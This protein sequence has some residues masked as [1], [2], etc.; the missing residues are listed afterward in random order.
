MAQTSKKTTVVS[1]A[2][3]T[4][5]LFAVLGTG[6]ADARSI[7][8]PFLSSG[9]AVHQVP[10]F[11]AKGVGNGYS[12]NIS[13]KGGYLSTDSSKIALTPWSYV[14]ANWAS[15]TVNIIFLANVT[16]NDFYIAFLYLT[17]S[18]SQIV[19]RIF[20]YQGG[21]YNTIVVEGTQ[22]ISN[23]LVDTNPVIIPTPHFDVKSQAPNSFTV[24]GREI[25]VDG[26]Y[27]TVFNSSI[28]LKLA[29][30]RTQV[31]DGP[32][33][34][35]EL[36][37]L[38]SD[39][40]GNYYFAIL[41]MQNSDGYHTI[42]EHQLRLNDFR[43]PG[44][45]TFDAQWVNGHFQSS[46]QIRLPTSGSIVKVDGFPFQANN[47]GVLSVGVPGNWATVEVPNETSPANGMRMR[48]SSWDNYGT[49]NP[50]N[51]SVNS[52]TQ[53]VA[54]YRVEY[55]LTIESK[56]SAAKGAGWYSAGTNATF[57]VSRILSSENGTRQVF[58]GFNGDYNS[59]SSTGYIVM[60]SA[61][62]VSTSWKTQYDVRLQLSGVPTNSTVAVN[63]N[64]KLQAVNGSKTAELWADNN[65]QLDV[66][67]PTTQIQA[68]SV[69]YNFKELQVDGQLSTSIVKVTKPITITIVFSDQQ[70][71]P[72]SINVEVTP[73]SA[74][75]GDPVIISGALSV[76]DKS[77][78]VH[79]SFSTDRENW[80]P[81]ANVS[82][83]QGGLFSY[84]WT[85]NAPGSY[86]V[87]AY[88][89][90]DT[91]HVSSSDMVP[92]KVQT[93]VPANLGGSGNLP[94]L[95]QEFSNVAN[96]WP[97]TSLPIALA[98]SFLTLGVVLATLL[99]S[100]GAPVVGYFIG[101]LL[102]GFVFVFPISAIILAYR[103]AKNRRPPSVVWLIPLF[104]LW[105]AAL[106]ILIA[107]GLFLTVPQAL[108]AASTILLVA[109]NA[110]LVPLGVS[111]LVARAVVK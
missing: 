19:L 24:F 14:T 88:W 9:S 42:L 90:G 77:S 76:G 93:D 97:F 110:L 45:R 5:A 10:D 53:L 17:N 64:G 99:V 54:N 1:L 108:L 28:T 96:G 94:N 36:W 15:G 29:S 106:A 62:R 63:V 101:S 12:L 30:L 61:K 55:S 85:P 92:V 84:I 52:L 74:I 4:I 100:G 49:A 65:A 81:I 48:F 56:Y 39:D 71:A 105:I 70:K 79:L 83:G 27:G 23:K 87:R 21:S 3:L 34:Y 41:Y 11:S 59:T 78:T 98:R 32:S 107:S 66:E 102:L 82:T 37:S 67:V 68:T 91:R 40:F 26:N 18:S 25:F 109:S 31:F 20:E 22:Q 13:P 60:N 103:A 80:Q 47:N 75:S 7:S 51:V 35:N 16:Q 111:V 43:T 33:D 44:G 38:L 6:A 57:S 50:L 72:S 95:S 2:L 73:V 8:S 104:T 89:Q 69:N 86:V 46:L 58:L